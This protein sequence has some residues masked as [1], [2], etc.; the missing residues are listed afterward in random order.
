[1]EKTDTLSAFGNTKLV[2][3]GY[4]FTGKHLCFVCWRKEEQQEPK[5][6]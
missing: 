5:G 2:S 6:E 4:K 3:V 1:M